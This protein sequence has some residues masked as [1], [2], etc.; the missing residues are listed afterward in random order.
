MELRIDSVH[1]ALE[2]LLLWSVKE[3]AVQVLEGL[4]DAMSLETFLPDITTGDVGVN[5]PSYVRVLGRNNSVGAK[6][7]RRLGMACSCFAVER[8]CS[9][10]K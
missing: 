2:A 7:S 5:V 4:G 1:A 8:L 3:S 6:L 9:L 10:V